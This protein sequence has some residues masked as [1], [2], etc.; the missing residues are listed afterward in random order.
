MLSKN[1]QKYIRSLSLKKFRDLDNC[2]V[3][4]G[5][6]IVC[7]LL[8][9]FRCELLCATSLFL[10]EY[11]P[12]I[13]GEVC[14]ITDQELAAISNQKCPQQVLA[15]FRKPQVPAC[16]SCYE[17]ELMLA[18]DGVQDPGN[19]GTIIRLADWFGIKHI[20]CSYECA[21]AFSPKVV[22][23]TMGAIARVAVEYTSLSEWLKTIPQNTP[24]YGTFLDGDNLYQKELPTHGIIV[25]GNEGKGISPEVGKLVTERLRIPSYPPECSTSESLNVAIATAV[26]CAEFRRR[27]MM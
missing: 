3:A 22:Q 26:I 11:R 13:D 20:V 4:E 7:E 17:S 24:V 10:Q 19:L 27:A 16:P 6:K 23:A 15:I 21:D 12:V 9:V 25:M 5:P 1:R 14:E 8:G 2:F 18:L